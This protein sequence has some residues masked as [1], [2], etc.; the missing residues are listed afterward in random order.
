M[1]TGYTRTDT[2]NNIA[3]GNTINASD[4][5]GEFDAIQSAMDVST[6]HNHDGTVGGG[7]PIA[8]LGP[9]QDVVITASAMR[10][11]TDNTVDLGTSSLEF[12][13]LYIDGT[14]N[15][16]TL[17]VDESATITANLT[18][19]GNAT[20]TTNL[21]VNGN[22]VIGS[23]DND[24]LDVKADFISSLIPNTDNLYDL[25]LSTNEWKDLYIDGVAYVDTLQVDESATITADL[26]V[27]GNT[28]LGN[29]TG[30]TVIVTARVASN[31]VPSADDTYDLGTSGNEWKDLYID[32]TAKVDIL[33]VDESAT[34]TADLTVNGNTTLGNATGD[35]VTFTARAASNFLP[36]VDGTYDLGSSA[37]EWQDLYIDGVARIDSLIADTVDINAGTAILSSA[38]VIAVGGGNI[39]LQRDD[40]T[41]T[42]GETLGELEFQAPNASA[43]SN[44]SI[45]T[46]RVKAVADAEFTTTINK[47]SL[48]L[49]TAD[50]G[51]AATRMEITGDGHVLP[52]TDDAYDLGASGTQWRNLWIDGTANIDSLVAD[53]ADIN[54]GT[55]D[56]VTITGGTIN[57]TSIGATTA[58][59]GT[60]TSVTAPSVTITGGTING[61]S[62]GATTTSSIAGT[63]GTFSGNLT[64]DTIGL[65]VDTTND[66]VGMGTASPRARLDITST[67]GVDDYQLLISSVRPNIVFED[68]STSATD[69][70][71]FGDANALAFLYGDASTNVKLVNEAMR[72][73]STGIVTVGTTDTSPTTN[74]V[75]GV[76]MNS[77]I[78]SANC[79][80]T[81]HRIGRRQ[82]GTILAFYSAGDTEGNIQIS[83]ASTTLTP[84]LGS[85]WSALSDWSRPEIKI[86][87][88]IETIN[89]LVDWKYVTIEVNGNQKK[90]AYNGTAVV[91][92]TVTVEFEDYFYD[93]IVG[94]NVNPLL[95]KHV[96]VK[97]SD[98][99]ES[100]SVYGV[101]LS[102]NT[103]VELDGGVWNDMN[104]AAVGNY[105]IRM[106]AGQTPEIGDLVVSDGT[107]CGIVQSDDII[108]AKT[109]AK[110]TNTIPQVV[111]DDGSF[112]VTCVIYCG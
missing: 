33:Q 59:A 58:A 107:G 105:V 95:N 2:A 97:V 71:I 29:S 1:A 18:V 64:V 20:I 37:N 49:Q 69:F 26:T 80:A 15:I 89:E 41:I 102:W 19:S 44:A 76:A 21:T 42:S 111:Y 70:Q 92:S 87:T 65:V 32:G 14:A 27:N 3:T 45:V 13:D 73:T 22:T 34:I 47:T 8:A 23:A 12:K 66:K 74:N 101:F 56:G 30:D 6:G 106:A 7:A 43:G 94:E 46:A 85:H 57:G 83:G 25:G 88:I 109:V 38:K 40:L 81:F 52:G 5:D 103:D 62:I 28:T 53:T 54:G 9:A 16:D 93:G 90:V 99:F 104:V 39:T 36:S 35:T 91:G 11:K 96:K 51:A 72:I 31:F 112:L 60:F 110:I 10:P 48:L 17:Q 24:T 4:L 75:A 78:F 98:T 61:T 55:I 82:D 67:I 84:F 77:G 108:R 100:K 68:S 50:A 63:T 86:G 79:E